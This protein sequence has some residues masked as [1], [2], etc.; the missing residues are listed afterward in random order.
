[1]I[2]K[3]RRTPKLSNKGFTLVELLVVIAIISV[4]GAVV[5]PNAFKAIERSQTATDQANV[6]TLNQ[7]TAFYGHEMGATGDI[8]EGFDTDQERIEE[9]VKEEFLEQ[10]VKPKR[11]NFAFVWD[12]DS[13]R[14]L[15]QSTDTEAPMGYVI[16]MGVDGL[17]FGSGWSSS[18]ITGRYTGK[19]EEIIIPTSIDGITI[20]RIFPD[21]FNA[22]PSTTLP[23]YEGAILTSVTFEDG[24]LI[25][26][27][28]ARAFQGNN[29][30]TIE[31]PDSLTRIDVR[32]FF[33]NPIETVVIPDSVSRIENN[34]FNN[35][36][37]ITVGDNLS[38]LIDGAING[39]NA[40]R[41]AYTAAG[42][43]AGTYRLVGGQWI[44]E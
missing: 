18:F 43:G 14:W 38:D 23:P 32:A 34:A 13:Q 5:A 26:H 16:S 12:I 3:T 17:E 11:R 27:I 40:F 20:T 19:A 21:V 30:S 9:L 42:G 8:F 25:E 24:S 44:K 41:D 28:H 36:V 29:I 31:L 1:M 10:E 39:N 37:E 7:V 22:M 6:R 35:L 4:L 33:N 2:I 15:Y